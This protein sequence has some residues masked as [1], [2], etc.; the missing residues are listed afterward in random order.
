[1]PFVNN[2]RAGPQTPA[3]I[4][5]DLHLTGNPRGTLVFITELILDNNI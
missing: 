3:L 2:T 5:V 1:M 4:L